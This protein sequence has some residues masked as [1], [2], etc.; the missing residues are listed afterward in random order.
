MRRAATVTTLALV[1]AV[2]LRAAATP[3]FSGTWKIDPSQASS[4]GGGRGGGR[5][6]GGGL[7]LGPSADALV[8][9]QDARSLVI[10]ETRGT[11]TSRLT[12]SLDGR[13]TTNPIAA[14][15]SAGST[16]TYVSH[17]QDDRLVTTITGPAAPAGAEPVRYQ[18]QRYL[19]KD[20]TL[21]V[22]TT[23]PGQENARKVVYV[24]AK[25]GAPRQVTSVPRRT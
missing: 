15:R 7:G 23:I 6:T 24:R 2:P 22:E 9:R 5:G 20:G 14:G 3:D 19:G 4:V 13:T 8:I 18:E 21:I 16:A 25:T 11:A 12:Y 10:D 17:W 1:L